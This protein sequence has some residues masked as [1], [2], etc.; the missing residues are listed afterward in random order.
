M[1]RELLTSGSRTVFSGATHSSGFRFGSRTT[2]KGNFTNTYTGGT[3]SF[4]NTWVRLKRSGNVFTGYRSSDGVNWTQMG[5]I[6]ISLPA[7]L[8]V[9]MAAASTTSSATTVVQYLGLSDVASQAPL[10]PATPAGFNAQAAGTSQINLAW[11]AVSGATLYRVQR[12]GPGQSSFTDLTTTAAASFND[13][14]LAANS[15]YS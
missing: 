3:P 15:A 7:T 12:K 5:T 6:N 8:Y 9:G 11:N 1:V 10:T 13:K 14:G 4:P 2:N